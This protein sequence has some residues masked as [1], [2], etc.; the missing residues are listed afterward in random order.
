[1]VLFGK[2]KSIPLVR[3]K[4]SIKYLSVHV[5]PVVWHM[6]T[7]IITIY[8][9]IITNNTIYTNGRGNNIMS[10]SMS[11]SNIINDGDLFI[12]SKIS[13][14]FALEYYY[15]FKQ[16]VLACPNTQPLILYALS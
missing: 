8:R 3:L 9:L 10:V 2:H 16:V 13:N 4:S 11:K 14:K 1:M 6:G 7:F 15:I 5:H 12:S